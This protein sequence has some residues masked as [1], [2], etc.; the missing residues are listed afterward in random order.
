MD[1]GFLNQ[2]RG[3]GVIRHAHAR[4]RQD[5]N[6]GTSRVDGT[7]IT[8]ESTHLIQREGRSGQLDSLR[9]LAIL[10]VLFDHFT[11]P[12]MFQLGSLSVKFFL[13]LSGF[14]IT[15]TLKRHLLSNKQ[16]SSGV[17]A[18]FY[19]RRAL[20][21]WP[22][23]YAIL[24]FF[25]L[26][27]G[28]TAKQFLVHATFITNI[29]Q[30][31]KNDWDIPWYFAHLWT[32]SVQEQYYL[33]WPLLFCLLRD[34][35]RRN[36]LMIMIAAAVAFRA[37]MSA[38]H[39]ET[40]IGIFTF[41]LASLDALAGGSLLALVHERLTTSFFRTA[42]IASMT[43]IAFIYSVLPTTMAAH[44]LLPTLWLIP[45]AFLTI[46]AFQRQLGAI[47]DMLEH[48]L[49]VYFGRISLGIYLLH[50][51]LWYAFMTWSPSTV[52]HQVMNPSWRTF[53]VLTPSTIA[54]AALSWH[55]LEKPLQAFRK[56][57]PYAKR[58]GASVT[59]GNSAEP[60]VA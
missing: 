31:W 50:I 22:L 42:S 51:P 45:L 49:L 41:P 38:A 19:G 10:F 52:S 9:F 13:M 29:A 11:H 37:G 23:H 43:A 32:I 30:A 39:L 46:A 54:L 15:D 17:L 56:Y 55:F 48:P 25:L 53:L 27:G 8:V 57:L 20:R 60:R 44:V 1:S 12:T 21:I 6:Q 59:Y 5:G 34:R 33:V 14:L 35:S 47:G 58:G 2:V 36:L 3:S 4:S 18:S 28:I 24:L 16:S 40:H 26:V 7:G